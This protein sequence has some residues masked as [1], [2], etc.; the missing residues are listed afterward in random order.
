MVFVSIDSEIF[1]DSFEL[2]LCVIVD[3]VL[4]AE[5]IDYRV[6]ADVIVCRV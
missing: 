5:K 2:N 6:G 4:L 1:L 3:T